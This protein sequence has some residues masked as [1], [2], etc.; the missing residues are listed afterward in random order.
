MYKN[1]LFTD[2]EIAIL[3]SVINQTLHE[4]LSVDRNNLTIIL[5]R[6]REIKPTHTYNQSID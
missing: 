6:L 1:V 3:K 2:K 5:N 4:K